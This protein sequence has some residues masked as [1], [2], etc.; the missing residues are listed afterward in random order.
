MNKMDNTNSDFRSQVHE[1][2]AG[3][4]TH[5]LYW[6]IENPDGPFSLNRVSNTFG[7]FV[8]WRVEHPGNQA[9]DFLPLIEPGGLIF[10]RNSIDEE[11]VAAFLQI[12]H[13]MLAGMSDIFGKLFDS[14][15]IPLQ[16]PEGAREHMMEETF[17]DAGFSSLK[18]QDDMIISAGFGQLVL[19]GNIDA[20]LKLLTEKALIRQ[21]MPLLLSRF[22]DEDYQQQRRLNLEIML[23]DLRKV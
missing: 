22:P 19:E 13:D 9:Q 20:S 10:D 5:D 16:L 6:D 8:A 15:I 11:D 12:H 21:S 7:E 17:Q 3:I 1:H 23:Q 4:L 14:S 18:E 2:A